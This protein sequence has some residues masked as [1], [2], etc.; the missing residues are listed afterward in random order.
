MLWVLASRQKKISKKKKGKC[1]QCGGLVVSIYVEW[2][3]EYFCE[4]VSQENMFARVYHKH[5]HSRKIFIYV[6]LYVMVVFIM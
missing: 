1:R 4:G 3:S 2:G 5:I 6:V